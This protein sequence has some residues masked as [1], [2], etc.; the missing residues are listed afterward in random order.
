MP[1]KTIDISGDIGLEAE[2]ASPAALFSEAARGF[3]AVTCGDPSVGSGTLKRVSA[4]AD[5]PEALLV[6]FLNELVYL[7]D[8]E[9]FV[10]SEVKAAAT[11]KAPCRAEAELH[12]EPDAFRRRRR[13][14]LVKAATY[15]GIEVSEINGLWRARIM[16]DI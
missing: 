12:G 8:T 16:L 13:G 15:H 2:A 3:Y 11:L 10:A 9:G 14:L 4:S 5:T 1:F 7:A 6:N